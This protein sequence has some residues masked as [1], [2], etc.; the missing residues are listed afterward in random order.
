MKDSRLQRR[1]DTVRK[2]GFEPASF[3]PIKSR[4]GIAMPGYKFRGLRVTTHKLRT[5]GDYEYVRLLAQ[6]RRYLGS[7]T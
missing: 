1:T 6:F 2:M 7:I 5:M 3:V 4:D